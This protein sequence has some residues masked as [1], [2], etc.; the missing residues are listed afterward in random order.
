MEGTHNPFSAR[1]SFPYT[2]TAEAPT[3]EPLICDVA[4]LRF[5]VAR[6]LTKTW[7][8]E[9]Q[10]LVK[11]SPEETCNGDPN[12]FINDGINNIADSIRELAC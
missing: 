10:F 7:D 9:K 1:A 11:K 12:L 2:V 4:V 5:C 6:G 8:H 3:Y